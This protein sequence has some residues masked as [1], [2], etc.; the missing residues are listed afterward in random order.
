VG[1]WDVA[2]VC[3]GVRD[4]IPHENRI[5]FRQQAPRYLIVPEILHATGY[6]D[7]M[8]RALFAFQDAQGHQFELQVA[9]LTRE[10]RSRVELVPAVDPDQVPA[11]PYLKN[12][13]AYWYEYLEDSKTLY[14]QYNQCRSLADHPFSEFTDQVLALLDDYPADRFVLDLRRNGGGDSAIATPLITGLAQR[15]K[16]NQKGRLFVFIGPRTASSAVLNATE[17]RR[18]TAAILVGEPTGQGPDVHGEIGT[19]ELPNS[20]LPVDYSATLPQ[21]VKDEPLA[22]VPDMHVVVSSVD[23]LAGRDPVMEAALAYPEPL[24]GS[25][26][27]STTE[28]TQPGASAA[29][30]ENGD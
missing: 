22:L 27:T 14:C 25:A 28:P 8:E 2:E 20:G 19:F 1:R 16:I 11:P 21:V 15:N 6:V 29:S 3:L 5:A 23:Y 24:A 17:L 26:P 4:L 12:D 13:T 7:D 30:T 10:Q 18:S 9:P